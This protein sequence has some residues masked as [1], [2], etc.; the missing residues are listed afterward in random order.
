MTEIYSVG[1]T[2]PAKEEK[3]GGFLPHMSSACQLHS[4]HQIFNTGEVGRVRDK[5]IAS[6]VLGICQTPGKTWLWR[7]D[8]QR[9]LLEHLL[10]FYQS[11]SNP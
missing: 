7:E 8:K 5:A 1:S 3:A 6:V 9:A 4:S 2:S 10:S 11:S